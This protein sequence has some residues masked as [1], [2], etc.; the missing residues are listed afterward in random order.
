MKNKKQVSI[1]LLDENKKQIIKIEILQ[2]DENK[3][4]PILNKMPRNPFDE[5]WFKLFKSNLEKEFELIGGVG[6]NI[7]ILSIVEEKNGTFITG[8]E[9]NILGESPL[10]KYI[11]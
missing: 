6:I 5:G 8:W 4:E 2:I 3:I 11:P 10:N 1:F 7:E 9:I